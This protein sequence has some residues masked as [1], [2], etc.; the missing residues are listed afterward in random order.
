[1][2]LPMAMILAGQDGQILTVNDALGQLVGYSEAELGSM[3]LGDIFHPDDL[4]ADRK[5]SEQLFRGDVTS[6]AAEM[7]F[8]RKDGRCVAVAVSTTAFRRKGI[9]LCAARIVQD[10]SE[11]NRLEAEIESRADSFHALCAAS[12]EGVL[13]HDDSEVVLAN[14]AL[15]TMFGYIDVAEIGKVPPGALFTTESRNVALQHLQAGNGHPIEV[16]GLR[17]TG[18]TFPIRIRVKSI[19]YEGRRVRLA[20]FLARSSSV[21][22]IRSQGNGTRSGSARP[23]SERELEV[24]RMLVKGTDNLVISKRLNISRRTVEHHVSHILTKLG[25]TNRT[26]AVLAAYHSGLLAELEGDD[27]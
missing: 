15:A 9:P 24:F 27:A 25:V 4:E 22:R 23:L 21:D 5:S 14:Q 10:L 19:R 18:S 6:F 8:K 11:R 2:S 13:I 3:K 16:S 26:A 7:R 1:M 17:K 12:M 20:T